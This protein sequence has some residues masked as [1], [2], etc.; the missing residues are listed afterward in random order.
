MEGMENK[1]YRM[2]NKMKGMESKIRGG[3]GRRKE[4]EGVGE[5][6]V[7][8]MISRNTVIYSLQTIY[9]S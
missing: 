3:G 2:E 7:L 6:H 9:L 8:K 5:S 1:M 4:G